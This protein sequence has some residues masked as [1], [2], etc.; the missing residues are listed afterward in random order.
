MSR[1]SSLAANNQ[2]VKYMLDVQTRIQKTQLQVATEKASQDYMGIARHSEHHVD[3]ENTRDLLQRF[4]QNNDLMD[5]RLKVTS[6]VIDGIQNTLKDFKNDILDYSLGSLTDETRVKNVQDA[7]FRA[8][9]D[10][11][12]HLNTDVNGQ[13]IFSG[14]RTSTKPVD[15]G[16]TNIGDLQSK[17]DGSTISYPTRR[18]THVHPKL[19]ASTGFPTNP[20]GAGFTDLTFAGGLGGT[21]TSAVA[22]AFGNIPVGATITIA[23]ATDAGNNTTFTVAA[24][25][26]TI[27]TVAATDTVTA[28]ANDTGT[29]ANIT[30]TTD[31]S[32]YSGDEVA[33][34]HNVAKNRSFN[35][36]TTGLDPAF[37][38]AIRAMYLIA[39]GDFGTAGGL[40]QN[41]TRVDDALYLVN[42]A[43]ESNP[44]GTP[45]FGTELTGN[46]LQMSMDLGYDRVL[47]DQTNSLNKNLIGFYDARSSD[48][49]NVDPLEVVSRM[50]D[51]QRA[52]ETSYQ[53][54]ARI[55]QLSLSNYL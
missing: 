22:G 27:I 39:Q 7:A 52:L 2:L 48:I 6:T 4:I 45:P 12:V 34:T 17:W 33:Q 35:L 1:I 11:E 37:E 41:T 10:L 38:K 20:T 5:L 14:A 8:L 53:A 21:I 32:Y 19:T 18:D 44:G 25:T 55:R 23:N 51:D 54:I 16:L 29:A 13:Y 46:I 31:V 28:R 15:F 26:G 30:M 3:I 43:L 50:L 42:G 47:I 40:D 36:D 9:K 49:E 24:N